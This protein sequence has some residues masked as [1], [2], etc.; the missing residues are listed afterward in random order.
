MLAWL[1]HVSCTSLMPASVAYPDI[2]HTDWCSK[3]RMS[4]PAN[5]NNHTN[6]P[7]LESVLGHIN[8][9][10]FLFDEDERQQQPI[11]HASP[12]AK[13]YLELNATNKNFPILVRQD[14]DGNGN[15]PR[16]S[17]SSAALDLAMSQSPGPDAQGQ[18]NGWSGFRHRHS[19]QSLPTNTL[20]KNSQVDEYDVGRTNGTVETPPSKSA[21]NNRRSVEFNLSYGSEQR[22]SYQA[23]PSQN[24]NGM[25][26]LQQS[27]SSN[28]VPTLKNGNVNGLNGINGMNGMNGMNG[29]NG[30]NGVNGGNGFNGMNGNAR[31]HAEQHLH[32]HNAS[33]G[34]VPSNISNRHSRELSAGFKDYGGAFRSVGSG[35]H[36]SA[37]PFG[38]SMTSAS[39]NMPPA[40]TIGSP[41]SQYSTLNN[42][43]YGYGNGMNNMNMNGLTGAMAG[44][45]MGQQHGAP[46]VFNPNGMYQPMAPTANYFNPTANPY[47]TYGPNG[48]IQDSQAR[49]IQTRRLQ[50][51]RC[52]GSSV[53]RFC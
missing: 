8:T 45:S 31:S 51:G 15:G 17:A 41:M 49:V 42:Q 46:P 19:Q 7:G 50:S 13:Q 36:A 53:G 37:A 9:A 39:M 35:L 28:D 6:M 24:S 48:R 2:K 10:A 4:M 25:P 5:L 30:T 29:V 34:R 14:G 21:A 47:A 32:N 27:F 44:M 52:F 23:S 18:S 12:D 11:P 3:N 43:Y 40:S 22:P 38:P 1:V 16:L 26:R 20:R 33:T